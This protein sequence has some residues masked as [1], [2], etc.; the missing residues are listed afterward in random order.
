MEEY[1]RMVTML[2][3]I[4]ASEL[5]DRDDDYV[6]QRDDSDYVEQIEWCANAILV[7]DESGPDFKLMDTLWHNHGF[8]VFPTEKDSFGWLC[9]AI[10]TKKGIIAFG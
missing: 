9:A 1:N 3:A 7:T 4:N 2:H 8:F 6:L 10:R 5:A